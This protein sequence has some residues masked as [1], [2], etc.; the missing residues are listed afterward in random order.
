MQAFDNFQN[1]HKRIQRIVRWSVILFLTIGCAHKLPTNT[2]GKKPSIKSKDRSDKSNDLVTAV[3][4]N[5]ITMTG[6][7]EL[8]VSK[9]LTK[10]VSYLPNGV[11]LIL[12]IEKGEPASFSYGMYHNIDKYYREYSLING[13]V[14]S[15]PI[16]TIDIKSQL[17]ITDEDGFD[18]KWNPS[19]LQATKLARQLVQKSCKQKS[20]ECL[21][22][23]SNAL[24]IKKL[25]QVFASA[26][27]RNRK[28]RT[29]QAH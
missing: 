7:W 27:Q 20:L 17:Q 15:S 23:Q 14:V 24:F 4:Q 13:S 3:N 26:Y 25:R 19:T 10:L 8:K 18:T 16:K 12:S 2:A 28:I 9:S 5:T 21:F 6:S 1:P 29:G 11:F 22:T